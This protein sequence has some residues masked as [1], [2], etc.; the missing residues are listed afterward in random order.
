MV[1]SYAGQLAI[2]HQSIHHKSLSTIATSRLNCY[3]NKAVRQSVNNR[4]DDEVWIRLAEEPWL[5]VLTEWRQRLSWRRLLWQGVPDTWSSKRESPATDGRQPDVRHNKIMI[6]CCHFDLPL[7]LFWGPISKGCMAN[8]H[9]TLAYIWQWPTVQIRN[10]SPL[11]STL[12]SF[13]NVMTANL[14]S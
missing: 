1:G 14:W 4:S 2:I 8:C 10:L 6:W 11:F 5:E 7:L 13:T 12:F 3:N 9:Q